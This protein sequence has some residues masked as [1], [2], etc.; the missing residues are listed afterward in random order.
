MSNKIKPIIQ[1]IT[2]NNAKIIKQNKNKIS[3]IFADIDADVVVIRDDNGDYWYNGDDIALI[4][5]YNNIEKALIKHIDNK[6]K[7][8]Y[9]ELGILDELKLDKKTIFIDDSGLFQ[10]VSRSKKPEAV[11]LW[12][13]I[14]KEILPELF[15]T[16]T[17][18]LPPK[19]SDIDRLNKSFYDD[20]ML[21][22]YQNIPAIYLAYIGKYNNKHILKYGKSNDFVTRDL[23]Q[24]RTMYKKFN[25]IKIWETMA[26]DKVESKIKTNFASKNMSTVLSKKELGIKCKQAT[27]RELVVLNEVNDLE[28]CLN[29]IDNVVKNTTLPQEDEYIKTINNWE[30][31]YELLNV[32]YESSLEKYKLL[33]N[34]YK[35]VA[36][37]NKLLKEKLKTR[38]R[39][40]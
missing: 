29:M 15:A 39:Y 11:K 31:K 18:T 34:N 22:D 16:G 23:E 33:E 30:H 7:K 10:L 25:V 5:K 8:Y 17:Y 4:L 37:T 26:N 3:E 14:T 12:R 1:K 9:H 20:N 19:E 32:K 13:K 24:H 40:S 36:E 35:A 6:Y 28:Y 27:K 38:G 21:S 2:N